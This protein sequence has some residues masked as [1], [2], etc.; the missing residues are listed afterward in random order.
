VLDFRVVEAGPTFLRLSW[1]PGPEPPQGYG[2]SYGVRGEGTVVLPGCPAFAQPRG[3]VVRV[4][5]GCMRGGD[6]GGVRR[7]RRGCVRACLRRHMC[8]QRR[9]DGVCVP[10][11]RGFSVQDLGWVCAMAR[12]PPCAP[13]RG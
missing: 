6:A 5:W 4:H 3:L 13:A 11:P 12:V 9:G 10:A 7:E 8:V 1:Q 2:L